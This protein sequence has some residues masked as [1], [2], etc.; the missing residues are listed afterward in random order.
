MNRRIPTQSHDISLFDVLETNESRSNSIIGCA[1]SRQ[2]NG[3][4][5]KLPT[6]EKDERQCMPVSRDPALSPVVD[7]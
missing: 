4:E 7:S 6:K 2:G 3:I 5:V 1:P